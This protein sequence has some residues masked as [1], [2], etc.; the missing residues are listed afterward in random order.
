MSNG[1]SGVSKARRTQKGK[2]GMA[3]VNKA[4]FSVVRV[5]AYNNEVGI[6]QNALLSRATGFLYENSDGELFVVTNKHVVHDPREAYY[7]DFLVVH[8][9]C[10]LRAWSKT[11]PV[12][13]E[14]YASGRAKW[15]TPSN[16]KVDVAVLPIAYED[17]PRESVAVP[18][19]NADALPKGCHS[20]LGSQAVVLGFPKGAFYDPSTNLP[21]CRIAT[22]ATLPWLG[23]KKRNCFLID[24]RLH[25]GMSGS[26]VI[27]MPRSI[28]EKDN[29]PVYSDVRCYLLGI[30]SSEWLWGG[31]PL[32]LNTVWPTE[33][34]EEAT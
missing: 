29:K 18:L 9:R 3:S 33:L 4:L 24:A 16:K 21:V 25:E 1:N 27:S 8:V 13:L 17:L 23:F 19:S 34:I 6:T 32:G 15:K 30:F 5:E 11:E 31:E 26:P 22:I 14:L 7:P 28:Y 12:K 20:T 2:A 10:K